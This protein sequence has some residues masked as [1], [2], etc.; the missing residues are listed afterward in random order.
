MPPTM[1]ICPTKTIEVTVGAQIT[2]DP[3]GFL[4]E[5]EAVAGCDGVGPWIAFGKRQLRQADR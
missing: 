1:S 3:N 4:D 2:L 5:A